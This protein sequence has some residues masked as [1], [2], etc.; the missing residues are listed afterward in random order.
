MSLKSRL[1]HLMLASSA[2]MI[3]GAASP[4]DAAVMTYGD[5][6]CLGFNCYGANDPTSG[7]TLQG[8]A[9]GT[10]SSAPTSFSHPL[11]PFPGAGDFAGTDTV[12]AG[13]NLTHAEDG[14]AAN[15]NPTLGPDVLSLDYS[16]LVAAG[17]H[18]T[19]LTFGIAADDFQNPH[20]LDAPFLANVNGVANADLTALLNSINTGGPRVEFFT[21]GLDISQLVPSNVLT[22]SID[23]GGTGGDGWAV[24]FAT[25]GVTTAADVVPEPMTMALF[26]AGLAAA[27]AVRRRKK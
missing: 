18:V 23:E 27:A 26:G 3:A 6:D 9:A 25:V 7:A 20:F 8:L 10:T 21:I 22:I 24:D 1:L 19:S 15:F 16:G 12:Y 5:K 17:S 4:A 14:Y 13:S 11:P 2:A